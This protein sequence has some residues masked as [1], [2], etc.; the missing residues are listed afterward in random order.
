MTTLQPQTAIKPVTEPHELII[1]MQQVLAEIESKELWLLDARRAAQELQDVVNQSIINYQSLA[2][3]DTALSNQQRRDHALDV[4]MSNLPHK[5]HAI[6]ADEARYGIKRV[7]IELA[8]CKQQLSILKLE[9][10]LIIA[11]VSDEPLF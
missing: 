1:A 2:L 3:Y 5:E 4:F 11:A 7:E 8:V 10:K 6:A 9:A